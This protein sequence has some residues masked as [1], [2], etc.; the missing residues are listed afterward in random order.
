VNPIQ[1]TFYGPAT[2]T[3]TLTTVLSVEKL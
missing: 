1:G 2:V 3:S